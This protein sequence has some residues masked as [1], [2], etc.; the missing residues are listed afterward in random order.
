MK[1]LKPSPKLMT[2]MQ[3]VGTIMVADWEK[4][5]GPDGQAIVSAFRAS[6]KK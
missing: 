5:A 4:Q 6:K 2:D 1:I 3:Q